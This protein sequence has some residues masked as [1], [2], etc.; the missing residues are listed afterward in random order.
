MTEY[1]VGSIIIAFLLGL[2]IGHTA[3]KAKGYAIAVYQF[4]QQMA[5]Q[6]MTEKFNSMFKEAHNANDQA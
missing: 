5:Q 1:I 2:V 3:G 6:A 4:Q